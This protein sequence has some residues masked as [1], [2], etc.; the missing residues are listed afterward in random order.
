MSVFDSVHGLSRV[1]CCCSC[2]SAGNSHQKS[3]V[4][5]GSDYMCRGI[6]SPSHY[7]SAYHFH[8]FQSV[9]SSESV[10]MTLQKTEWQEH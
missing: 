10:R 5:F 8:H 6:T 9:R 2:E 3:D 4:L 1:F 7:V